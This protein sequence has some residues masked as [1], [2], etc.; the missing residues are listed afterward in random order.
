VRRDAV[1]AYLHEH[2]PISQ[3][4][5]PR[6]RPQLE[7]AVTSDGALVAS[8]SG[9]YVAIAGQAGDRSAAP[10]AGD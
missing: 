9:A 8:F 10:G 5:R 6:E 7:A 4:Q 3:A 1:E 2:I